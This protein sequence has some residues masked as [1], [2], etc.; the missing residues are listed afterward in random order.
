MDGGFTFD[1][2]HDVFLPLATA[3]PVT[4]LD[5]MTNVAMAFPR[6]PMV[7]AITAN[8]LQL[9]SKGRFRLGLGTQVK[10]HIEKRFGSPW[11]KP[12]QHMREWVLA[13]NAIFRNWNEGEPLDF[14]GEYTTHTLSTPAFSPAPNPYGPPKVLVGALGPRMNEMA[15]EVADGVLVMPFNSERHMDERT[16]PAIR[17]GLETSGGASTTTRSA[18]R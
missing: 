8:D 5:L 11:G 16:M 3:A 1:S 4:S 9:L 7:L 18:S 15:A 12:V 6:S 17:R 13:I 14:R 2:G 10:P